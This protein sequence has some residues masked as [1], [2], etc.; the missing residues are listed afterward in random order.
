MPRTRGS[1]V[2]ARNFVSREKQCSAAFA[3]FTPACTNSVAAILSEDG[4]ESTTYPFGQDPAFNSGSVV[5]SASVADNVTRYYNTSAGAV[6]ISVT[7]LPRGFFTSPV[8]GLEP[9]FPIVLPVRVQAMGV[10]SKSACRRRA[11][12]IAA[13]LSC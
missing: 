4:G 5:Y 2:Q 12:Y 11:R 9:G 13:S 7:G 8:P 6:D 1:L 3:R 10:T